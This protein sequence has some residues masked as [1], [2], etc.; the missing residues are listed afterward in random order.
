M[1]PNVQLER[2]GKYPAVAYYDVL[3]QN[4]PEETDEYTRIKKEGIWLRFEPG[5]T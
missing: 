1:S 4:L 5:I 2:I 3:S